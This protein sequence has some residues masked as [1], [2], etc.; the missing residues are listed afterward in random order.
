MAGMKMPATLLTLALAP[1]AASAG[2]FD[3]LVVFGDSLSDVGN[4]QAVTSSNVLLPT[5]PGPSYFD[6]RFSNGPVYVDSLADG[7]GLGPVAASLDGGDVYAYGGARTSGTPL[8]ASLVVQDVDDQV[9][10]FLATAPADLADDLH[11]VYAGGNDVAALVDNGGTAAEARAAARGLVGQVARLRDAGV[12]NVLTPNLPRLGLTPRFRGNAEADALTL[13]FNDELAAA[14]DDLDA[15]SPG[16]TTYRL[17]VQGLFD[18]VVADPSAFGFTNVSDPAAPG[19]DPGDQSYDGSQIVPTP[20]KYVFWDEF[21]PT[22][23]AHDLLGERA[24]AAIPE[25]A[26]LAVLGF[27]LLPLR[28]RRV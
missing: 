12:R 4:V 21:H 11:V 9:T 18:A 6:G 24:L 28:R 3:R 14:L 8:P 23:A 7:L 5:T 13:A 1:A 22:A 17:D 27:A 15:A 19:L 10:L 2:P 26:G 25:P 20:D 16:L